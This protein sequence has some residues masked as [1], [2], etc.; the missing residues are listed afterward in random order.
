MVNKTLDFFPFMRL[1][2]SYNSFYFFFPAPEWFA[3]PHRRSPRR[4]R[5]LK[6]ADGGAALRKLWSLP[7]KGVWIETRKARN[8]TA[9]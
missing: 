9:S 5:G 1:R 8:F 3:F 6:Y 4:E 2:S 7:T